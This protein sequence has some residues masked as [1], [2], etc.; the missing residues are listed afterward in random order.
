MLHLDQYR[1]LLRDLAP[2]PVTEVCNVAGLNWFKAG[3]RRQALRLPKHHRKWDANTAKDD[4][5]AERQKEELQSNKRPKTR[6]VQHSEGGDQ[7]V[8]FP[9][10]PCRK[11][12]ER[13]E[14]NPTQVQAELRELD[15]DLLHGRHHQ[16][17]DDR[18]SQSRGRSGERGRRHKETKDAQRRARKEVF[19]NAKPLAK[20][21][22]KKTLDDKG[23][24]REPAEHK[25]GRS[26]SKSKGP[27]RP[28][29]G[30]F[31]RS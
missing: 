22:W 19:R 9:P 14:D 12:S 18:S 2:K 11:E 26:R 7:H 24:E 21:S 30:K 10:S 31:K 3:A 8:L 20:G 4:D 29:K 16:V 17:L 23:L 13:V 5:T 6:E 25:R 28:E 1:Q 15:K 27:D